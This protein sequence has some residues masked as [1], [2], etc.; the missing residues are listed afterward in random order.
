MDRASVETSTRRT[1][2]LSEP[3]STREIDFRQD[4]RL[5]DF[6]LLVVGAVVGDGIYVVGSMG[7]RFLGPAQ[8]VAWMVGGLLAA[9]IALAFVQ[10]S[11]IDPEVGGSYAYARK[12]FGPFVGFLAGWSLYF[13]EWVAI[14]AFPLAFTT[15]FATLVAPLSGP[16]ALVLRVGLIGAVT[17]VNLAGVRQGARA[18]DFLTLAKLLPLLAVAV[19]GLIF[20]MT[21]AGQASG[22]LSPF[23]PL[24]WGS[25]GRAMLPIFW[26]YAGFELAVLPAGEVR[27]ARRTLP[28]GLMIGMAIATAVYL[29]VAFAVVAAIPWQ[30][31]AGSTRP[32]APVIGTIVSTFG[33]PGSIGSR[34]AS[35]GALVSITGVFVVF[36]LSLARLSYALARDGLFPKP[37]AWVHAGSGAPYVGILF[38]SGSALVCTTLFSLGSLLTT[39][40]VF[41]SITYCLTALSAFA[42]VGRQPGDALHIPGLRLL[43]L[44]AAA[45]AVYLTCQASTTQLGLGA[46]LVGAGA[47]SYWLPR[48]IR[49]K[50]QSA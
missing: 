10:C 20:A 44:L 21:H 16:E 25:F 15:Y 1:T 38:Q 26:A 47:A 50:E 42:L 9:L 17:A 14:S 43:L 4:L 8:I 32:I 23:A 13:G 29:G 18:N 27:D 12:A 19:L 2:A 11:K 49:M 48:L 37:F 31:T 45:G 28:L 3:P 24:G 7:A 33:G 5:P 41:L 46:I 34:A 40:V 39:A 36:T 30:E 22:H 35:A 6:T